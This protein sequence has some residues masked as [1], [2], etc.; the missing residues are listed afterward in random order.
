MFKVA[1]EILKDPNFI[2]AI[3]ISICFIL[4]GFILRYKNVISK[5]G[6]SI[7]SFLVLKV[8]LP[9]LAFSA[10]MTDF[11]IEDFK[12]NIMVFIVS[13]LLFIFFLFIFNILCFKLDKKRRKV[14]AI[15]I[16]IGQLTFFAIPV[17]KTIYSNNLSEAMIPA[18][19]MTLSFRFILYIYC[20]FAISNLEFNKKEVK[21]SLK[22]IFLNP[23]MIAM[24]LGLIIWLT[25]N[26]DFLKI[27]ISDESYSIFRI[28]KTLPSIYMVIS[29]GEK[30]NTP[31]AMLV[32]GCILGE[33]N[34]VNAIKDKLAWLISLA[35][36]IL[37]P[38][39][40]LLIV[41]L[42]QS[43]K[44]IN[45]NEYD[46]AVIGLGFAAPLSAVVSTYCS[47]YENEMELASRV[48]FISTI[49][50]VI[51][52]PLL[53]MLIKLIVQLPMFN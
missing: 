41:M 17:L 9:C 45:F 14:I 23:V 36:T 16:V 40:A 12:N 27:N 3:L 47:K 35:K 33:A 4:L 13:L 52:Y 5:D 18:N 53:Y 8:S 39:L 51:T 42:L 22:T 28:D 20:Y 19:M 50:C 46:V 21:K 34:I 26:I 2:G 43:L 44:V 10:F 25:Q 15:L 29:T 6:K 11:K 49:L 1:L 24:F 32:I 31:L 7:L 48:T 30:L 38:I 37:V